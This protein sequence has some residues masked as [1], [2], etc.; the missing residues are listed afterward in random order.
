MEWVEPEGS[1]CGSIPQKEAWVALAWGSYVP[2]NSVFLPLE[3]RP[4]ESRRPAIRY[5]SGLAWP[6]PP[7]PDWGEPQ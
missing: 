1:A 4:I 2:F 6:N 3:S 5:F 7:L